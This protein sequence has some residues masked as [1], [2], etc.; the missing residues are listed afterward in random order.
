MAWREVR[1][2]AWK[3]KRGVLRGQG[4]G[5]VLSKAK[6][7]PRGHVCDAGTTDRGEASLCWVCL[8]NGCFKASLCPD[9]YV[10]NYN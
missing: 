8:R 3:G 5:S 6:K 9:S 10:K 4:M 7:Q 1:E 2:G